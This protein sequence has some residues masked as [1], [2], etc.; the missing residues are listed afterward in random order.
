[1]R[2]AKKLNKIRML[3]KKRA[4]SRIFGT[5][6]RPRLSVF[7]S[8]KNIYA[9]LI[10]DGKGHTL[11]SVYGKE[12]KAKYT[13]SEKAF[14]MGKILAKKAGALGIVKAV[15]DKGAYKY[16]GRIKALADGAREEGMKI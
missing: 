11:V 5:A 7:R 2:K 3:R 6:I 16:H 12:I 9:Q 10:D 8:N 14:E 15:F 1:M 13:K 4:R